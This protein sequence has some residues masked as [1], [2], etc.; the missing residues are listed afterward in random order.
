MKQYVQAGYSASPQMV[1]VNTL[2]CSC[3]YCGLQDTKWLLTNMM[4]DM[5]QQL[6]TGAQAA[7]ARA[8]ATGSASP[9]ASNS[10]SCSGSGAAAAGRPPR[11][12]KG[13]SDTAAK[14]NALL[15]VSLPGSAAYGGSN[16]G[17]TGA[18]A[19]LFGSSNSSNVGSSMVS[20]SSGAVPTGAAAVRSGSGS[21]SGGRVSSSQWQQKQW[22]QQAFGELLHPQPALQLVTVTDVAR[23]KQVVPG[24][25]AP[26]VSELA[27]A[28]RAFPVGAMNA[29]TA[30]AA[31]SGVGQEQEQEGLAD[32]QFQSVGVAKSAMQPG[33]LHC[34]APVGHHAAAI[35]SSPKGLRLL[36]SS[37]QQLPAAE[38]VRSPC[39]AVGSGGRVA[40]VAGTAAVAAAAGNAAPGAMLMDHIPVCGRR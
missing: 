38:M 3:C 21:G 5:R 31:A 40:A 11:V 29:A 13:L 26:C 22:Q 2:N 8:A 16:Y 24:M 35:G 7:A 33:Q 18:G 36:L 28:V 10:S 9:A 23:M 15:S 39:F 19:G 14:A 12:S 25:Q 34:S 27:A 32:R 4:S 17:M 37:Q 6:D 1:H 30:A 20:S